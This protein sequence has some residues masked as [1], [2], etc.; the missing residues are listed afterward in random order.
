VLR[1]KK[2]VGV[3][4]AF[5]RAPLQ[6]PLALK[7]KVLFF[8]IKKKWLI[9]RGAGVISLTCFFESLNYCRIGT[10]VSLRYMKIFTTILAFFNIKE[11]LSF[12]MVFF[13]WLSLGF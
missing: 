4:C 13:F 11:K 8:G 3:F 9:V 12:A 2:V 7:P 1:D 5:F 6:L 10:A